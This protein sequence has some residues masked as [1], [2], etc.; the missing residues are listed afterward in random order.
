MI[1]EK[2]YRESR[3]NANIRRDTLRINGYSLFGLTHV[4]SIS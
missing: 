1:H 4:E 3:T 2:K